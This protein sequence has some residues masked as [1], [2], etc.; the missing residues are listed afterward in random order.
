[1]I[2]ILEQ[3]DDD[4]DTAATPYDNFGFV[5]QLLVLSQSIFKLP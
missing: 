4:E 1:M 2:G 3:G 5:G